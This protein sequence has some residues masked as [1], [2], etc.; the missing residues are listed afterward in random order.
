MSYEDIKERVYDAT[1]NLYHSGLIRLSS[2][3]V[4]ARI[5]SGLV[6]ITPP[7]RSYDI[8][9]PEDICIVSLVGKP[10]DSK[11]KPSSE[12]PLHTTIYREMSDVGGI[13][14]THSVYTMTFAASDKPLPLINIEALAALSNGPI[15]VAQYVSPGSPVAGEVARRYFE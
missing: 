11:L 6:A 10:E 5:N 2:G 13:V 9:Q 1:M 8:L 15:P 3:N 4:S 7:G 12:T 14:H